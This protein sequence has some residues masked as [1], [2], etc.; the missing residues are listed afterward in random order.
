MPDSPRERAAQREEELRRLSRDLA[1]GEP[2][3]ERDIGVSAQGAE[4]GRIRAQEAVPDDTD[5]P[6][7]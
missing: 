6:S 5:D 2:M 1:A 7:H 3:T 4:E